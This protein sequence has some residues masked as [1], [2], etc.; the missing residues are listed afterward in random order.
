MTRC[1]PPMKSPPQPPPFLSP[2]IGIE[3]F[4]LKPADAIGD[5]KSTV[6]GLV[7]AFVVSDAT[8]AEGSMIGNGLGTVG[9]GFAVSGRI[10]CGSPGISG[11]S[12]K[13]EGNPFSGW[14][15]STRVFGAGLRKQLARKF[16]KLLRCGVA[17]AGADGVCDGGICC[18]HTTCVVPSQR[19]PA[20]DLSQTLRRKMRTSGA[21]VRTASS[22]MVA[23]P[24]NGIPA[25][26]IG[27]I[28][29]N[30]FRVAKVRKMKGSSP[31]P[32]PNTATR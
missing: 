20:S 10:G 14:Q 28:C 21:N 31:V 2:S 13:G 15:S 4:R 5:S 16:L 3:V 11:W 12:G 25:I 27:M 8:G 19:M 6:D 18:D 26:R 24:A 17:V 9:D 22:M 23:Y 32:R 7:A 29:Q 30:S 1:K